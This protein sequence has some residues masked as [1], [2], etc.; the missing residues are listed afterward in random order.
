MAPVAFHPPQRRLRPP[1]TRHPLSY[2]NS[3]GSKCVLGDAAAVQWGRANPPGGQASPLR[4][5]SQDLWT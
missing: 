5:N 2:P 1:F 3:S 4:R